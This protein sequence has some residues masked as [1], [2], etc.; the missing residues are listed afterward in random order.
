[1]GNGCIEATEI[2]IVTKLPGLISDVL[3]REG[4]FVTAG[5]VFTE[6]QVDALQAK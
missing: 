1:M 4:D 5:L 2:G 3:V 6:M